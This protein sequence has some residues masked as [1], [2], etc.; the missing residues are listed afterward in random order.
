[1]ENRSRFENRS[2]PAILV[3]PAALFLAVLFL[4]PLGI[5]ALF[6]FRSGTFGPESNVFTLDHYRNFL[7]STAFQNLLWRSVILSF[8]VSLYTVVAAYP[9]AYFLAFQAGSARLFLLTIIIVPAWVSY[10]LRVLS[11]KVILG[12]SGVLASFLEWLGITPSGPILIY[13][14]DA[15]IVTLVYV[16]IP[17]VAL[18]I[19]VALERIDRSLL[20][21]AVDLGCSRWE[22]FLRVTLPLSMPGVI[23]G[24]LF[25]FIPTVGEYVTPALV[26]GPQG[27]MIGNIIFDQ[28]LRGLNWPFGAVMSLAMLVIILIPLFLIGR[29]GRL[30]EL[31]GL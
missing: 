25:V 12:G 3:L 22:A 10:L 2:R 14:P 8:W 15:V 1:L 7:D 27:V 17:F 23:A 4:L 31:T 13:S 6:T 18:P 21:A 29:F 9:V 30:S 26:G 5:M 16:W 19:F 11:W 20:E 28:F 24:F